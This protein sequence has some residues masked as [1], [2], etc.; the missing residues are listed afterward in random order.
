MSLS[1]TYPANPWVAIPTP[2]PHARLRLFCLPS[3][4]GGATQYRL[5]PQHLP[6][7][8]ELCAIQLPG[9]ESR[10]R[11]PPFRGMPALVAALGPALLPL[12]D[13]P[14]ALFGHSMGALVAFE[15]ARWLRDS[16]APMPMHLFVSG[17]RSPNLPDRESPI[18]QLDDA[19]FIRA[20][21]ER[22]NGIP[23]AILHDAELL[24]LFL[25]TLRADLE[26]IETFHYQQHEAL[27]LPISAFA[28][29]SDRRAQI[30]ELAAWQHHTPY[31]LAIRQFPGD[32]FFLQHERT[33]LI[34]TIA[35]AL[36]PRLAREAVLD[37]G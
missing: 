4:G 7:E 21:A 29:T 15:L 3:A 28:G 33:A 9:R 5:W 26:V 23:A 12:L 19:V 8:I 24:Q 13:M 10:F 31:P 34:N 36:A 37:C 27:P 25:P 17:R 18:H 22:Y 1:V 32:H 11:E 2:R 16:G 14:F 35:E 30:A 6:E 20:L